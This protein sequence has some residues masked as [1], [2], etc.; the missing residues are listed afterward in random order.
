M[1]GAIVICSWTNGAILTRPLP[2]GSIAT[3]LVVEIHLSPTFP[4]RCSSLE[5]LI[6]RQVTSGIVLTIN[7]DEHGTV[8][9]ADILAVAVFICRMACQII[10][11]LTIG[12]NINRIIIQF[13]MRI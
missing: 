13:R 3:I 4:I 11:T 2:I 9:F 6:I 12:H 7:I 1:H 10:N 5:T 8:I